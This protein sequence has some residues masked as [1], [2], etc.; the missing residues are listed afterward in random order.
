MDWQKFFREVLERLLGAIQVCIFLVIDSGLAY[1]SLWIYL[2]SGKELLEL[3]EP[4]HLNDT[5]IIYAY[6]VIFFSGNTIDLSPMALH[7]T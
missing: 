2:Y 3:L 7:K 5:Q 1:L 6:I 4:Y